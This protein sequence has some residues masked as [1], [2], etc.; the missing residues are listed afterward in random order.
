MICKKHYYDRVIQQ[1]G[2]YWLVC[3]HCGWK[4][5]LIGIQTLE[6]AEELRIVENGGKK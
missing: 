6:Q 3:V 4:K 5:Q 2:F 1:A